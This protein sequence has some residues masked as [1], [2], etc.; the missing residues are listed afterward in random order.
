MTST[1]SEENKDTPDLVPV[2]V[3]RAGG[4]GQ[5]TR[6]TTVR[7]CSK[8]MGRAIVITYIVHHVGVEGCE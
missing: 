4:G 7:N 5:P 6:Q 8:S 2:H 3:G 1:E